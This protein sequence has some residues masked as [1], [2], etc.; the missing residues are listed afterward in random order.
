MHLNDGLMLH[1]QRQRRIAQGTK[2]R[3]RDGGLRA[4][5]V[6]FVRGVAHQEAGKRGGSRWSASMGMSTSAFFGCPSAIPPIASK[7]NNS[8]KRSEF[9][10]TTSRSIPIYTLYVITINNIILT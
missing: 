6:M 5:E 7:R 2:G 8:Q 1:A 9:C 4:P 3:K 10:E